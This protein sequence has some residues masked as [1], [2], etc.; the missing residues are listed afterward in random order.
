MT[1]DG[2]KD[3]QYRLTEN[4]ASYL[5]CRVRSRNQ[6]LF[7]ADQV[8]GDISIECFHSLINRIL[9]AIQEST[10]DKIQMAIN[11]VMNVPKNE[12]IIHIGNPINGL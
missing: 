7:T 2:E 3:P 11:T 9:K 8:T 4:L 12:I 1:I 6:H 10:L 5:H